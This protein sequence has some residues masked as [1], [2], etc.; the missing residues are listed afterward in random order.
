MVR[1]RIWPGLLLAAA[2]MLPQTSW[3]AQAAPSVM[4][5][6]TGTPAQ[7]GD[8]LKITVKGSDLKDVI[9]Y[10]LNVYYDPN[11]IEFKPGSETTG[12]I[13]FSTNALVSSEGGQHVGVA[14]VKTALS[15]SDTGSIEMASFTFTAK[16]R[17]T[18]RLQLKDVTLLDSNMNEITPVVQQP[19]IYVPIGRRDHSNGSSGSGSSG[20]DSGSAGGTDNGADGSSAVIVSSEQLSGSSSGQTDIELAEGKD[21]IRLPVHAGELLGDKSLVVTARGIRLELPA[22][23]LAQLIKDKSE[24]QLQGAYISLSAKPTTA[25]GLDGSLGS[26]AGQPG[27][28]YKPAG[29]AFDVRLLLVSSD[30]STQALHQFGQPVYLGLQ[31]D[32]SAN[33]KLSGIYYLQDNG[34]IEY[35]GGTYANGALTAPVTHF[36]RYAVLEWTKQFSDLPA[37]HWAAPVVQELA[38][39]HMVTGTGQTTFEPDRS[40]TR[41][42]FVT[43]LARAMKLTDAGETPFTDVSPADWFAKD[44]AAAYKAGLVQGQTADLFAPNDLISREEM[45]TLMMRSYTMNHQQPAGQSAAPFNDKAQISTWAL[46]YVEQAASLQLINGRAEGRFEPKGNSTRAEA[47][48]VMYNLLNAK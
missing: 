11:F 23:V 48:Q 46:P 18:A 41:A 17:G 31:V 7:A 2:L 21:E 12:S 45:V 39:R 37:D 38:A 26:A 30:G 8:E 47:S 9:A 6:A 25:G 16:Q 42:E 43:M 35:I 24:D 44:V 10:D 28:S 14:H 22:G 33:A 40:V 5:E 15:P 34:V 3:A 1:T 27:E 13:G 19:E 36:S 29:S 4:M 32:P 20:T